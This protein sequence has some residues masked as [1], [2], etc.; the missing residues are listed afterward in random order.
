MIRRGLFFRLPI[1][2][3]EVFQSQISNFLCTSDR[4]VHWVCNPIAQWNKYFQ[5]AQFPFILTFYLKFEIYPLSS[6]FNIVSMHAHACTLAGIDTYVHTSMQPS[7]CMNKCMHASLHTNWCTSCAHA[8][9]HTKTYTC[10]LIYDTFRFLLKHL[11]TTETESDI[12]LGIFL[13]QNQLNEN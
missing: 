7:V 9:I 3:S 2:N 11:S 8:Y 4:V 1:S 13:K 6:E 12:L 10:M 5:L